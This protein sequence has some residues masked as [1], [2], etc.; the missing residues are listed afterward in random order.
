METICKE[1]KGSSMFFVK[2]I[3]EKY[4]DSFMKGDIFT[5]NFKYF[6]D[7][8]LIH[9]E[10]GIGDKKD[11]CLPLYKFTDIRLENIDNPE[12]YYCFP[13]ADSFM[14]SNEKDNLTPVFCLYDISLEDVQVIRETDN[15]LRLLLDFNDSKKQLLKKEFQGKTHIVIIEAR[16][17]INRIIQLSNK[18]GLMIDYGKV[19]YY[20]DGVNDEKRV[21]DYTENTSDKFLWKD[22][23]FNNQN[24]FRII[25]KNRPIHNGQT[26]LNIGDMS[27]ISFCKPIDEMLD[28]KFEVIYNFKKND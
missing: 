2:F 28:S 26:I 24:E 4:L 13:K 19:T 16:A 14:F 12:E 10:K 27:Q 22:N 25:F 21:N 11:G 15:E 9:G 20:E 23:G 17:F 1:D 3:E 8:E 6:Q 18:N 7:L 5:N